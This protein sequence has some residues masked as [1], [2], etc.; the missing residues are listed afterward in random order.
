MKCYF[1]LV[2]SDALVAHYGFAHTF[3][4][5]PY[6]RPCVV[7]RNVTYISIYNS[8]NRFHLI[9]RLFRSICPS[10]HS[11]DLPSEASQLNYLPI[12][13]YFCLGF[14]FLFYNVCVNA[15][16]CKCQYAYHGSYKSGPESLRIVIQLDF[17]TSL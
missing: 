2:V 16:S 11:T 5:Q 15:Q 3:H 9:I 13:L 4:L 17:V 14:L 6:G 10:R 8:G 12:F 7:A 1:C